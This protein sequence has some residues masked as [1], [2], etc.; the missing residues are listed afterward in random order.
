MWLVARGGRKLWVTA[1]NGGKGHSVGIMRTIKITGHSNGHKTTTITAMLRV[2]GHNTAARLEEAH[3]CGRC[4]DAL[5]ADPGRGRAA[6]HGGVCFLLILTMAHGY[7]MRQARRAS[8]WG[9]ATAMH[10]G[11]LSLWVSVPPVKATL[12]QGW[13][14]VQPPCGPVL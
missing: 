11:C 14:A 4:A 9:L 1:R 13:Q 3:K 8:P 6:L 7:L 5:C 12:A 2:C 10:H